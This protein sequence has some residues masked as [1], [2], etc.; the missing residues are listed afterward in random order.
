M[1]SINEITMSL[2]W[3]SSIPIAIQVKLFFMFRR[4]ETLDFFEQF[5]RL[6]EK[7]IIHLP[8]QQDQLKID[9]RT[10][11][12]LLYS[13]ML[14]IMIGIAG[15]IVIYPNGRRIYTSNQYLKSLFGQQFLVFLSLLTNSVV[16]SFIN[17]NE[18]VPIFVCYQ[19]GIAL[20][21][22]CQ[23]M[24]SL[25]NLASTNDILRIWSH[26]NQVRESTI[27]ADQLY[28]FL[29]VTNIGRKFS[30]I[31]ACAYSTLYYV[32]QKNEIVSSDYFRPLA[33][34]FDYF[35]H[36][37]GYECH[38]LFKSHSSFSTFKN[39]DRGCVQ[40][41]L[42]TYGTRGQG[43]IERFPIG[44]RERVGCLSFEIIINECQ[45]SKN[46]THKSYDFY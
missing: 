34:R 32:F 27:K 36:S 40:P 39:V 4:K 17:L 37:I 9:R 26:Y 33:I 31:C 45:K 41:I 7:L 14:F 20:F 10:I 42:E 38:F 12:G 2:I 8:S 11:Y 5:R 25:R 46:L 18:M 44:A 28:G 15:S 43:C 19:S 35:K 29:I 30:L 1:S 16:V 6:E 23:E 24:K 13:S 21:T 3:F 22:I